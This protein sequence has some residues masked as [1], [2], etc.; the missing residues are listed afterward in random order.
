MAKTTPWN[1]IKNFVLFLREYEVCTDYIEAEKKANY[2]LKDYRK[3]LDGFYVY[4][5]I[6]PINKN[7]FY[8]GKGKNQRAECHYKDYCKGKEKNNFKL[9]E[10]RSFAKYGYKPI[11][12]IVDCNLTEEQA[13]KLE[14]RLI[15]RLYNTLTNIS[16]NENEPNI[17]KREVRKLLKNMPTYK[18]WINGIY[19]NNKVVFEILEKQDYGV[20]LYQLVERNLLKLAKEYG[21]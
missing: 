13:Y 10:M 4:L 5:L 9:N 20:K 17:V 7:I 18:Q 21:L 19:N 8:V 12:K 1:K 14:T 6:N 2:K 16:K 3:K 11:I 15:K